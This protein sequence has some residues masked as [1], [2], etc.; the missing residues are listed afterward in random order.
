MTTRLAL[1]SQ[2]ATAASRRAAFP[3]DE[4]LEP[5]ALEGLAA[6]RLSGAAR[7]SPALAARQT[8]EALGLSALVDRDLAD[9]DAGRWRG[10]SLAQIAAEHPADLALWL[11]DPD[12]AGHGGESRAALCRRAEAWLAAR[13]GG[14]RRQI[15]VTHAAVIR[16]LVLHVLEAPAGSFWRIDIAP[17]TVTELGHDGRRWALRSCGVPLGGTVG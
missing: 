9:A 14:E 16:A 15:A 1:I 17:L 7:V 4:A 3:A 5:A 13:S 6:H 11:S 12:F 10:R 2:G 8:A